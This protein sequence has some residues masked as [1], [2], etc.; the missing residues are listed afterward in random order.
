MKKVALMDPQCMHLFRML[1]FRSSCL[2]AGISG[3]SWPGFRRI[4]GLYAKSRIQEHSFLQ[5]I[6]RHM[7]YLYAGILEASTGVPI[8]QY[9]HVR[10]YLPSKLRIML[11][12]LLSS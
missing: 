9:H 4:C 3:Y 11:Y 8:F 10:F 5:H 12:S 6:H 1:V 7:G 2:V